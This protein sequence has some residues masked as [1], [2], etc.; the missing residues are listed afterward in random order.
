[1]TRSPTNDEGISLSCDS[2][3]ALSMRSTT[4]SIASMLTGRFSQAFL[5][6]VRIFARSKASRRP[7]FL[8]TM[9][10]TSSTNS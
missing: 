5:M 6:P 10:S 7:S 3:Q 9:G 2:W 8:T 1:M 4:A